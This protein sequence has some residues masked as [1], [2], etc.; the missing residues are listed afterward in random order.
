M[1]KVRK[2]EETYLI[3]NSQEL[4]KEYT[5]QLEISR[6]LS[7]EKGCT[8]FTGNNRSNFCFQNSKPETIREVAKLL[9][10]A[11]NVIENINKGEL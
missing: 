10:E 6:H 7:G 11:A 3:S 2:T 8:I 4:D 5:I 1:I 9:I